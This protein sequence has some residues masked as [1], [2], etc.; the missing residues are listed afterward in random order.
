M[1]TRHKVLAAL[2]VLLTV[3]AWFAWTVLTVK[4]DL[5]AGG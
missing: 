3:A 5:S 1:R 2:A 4:S